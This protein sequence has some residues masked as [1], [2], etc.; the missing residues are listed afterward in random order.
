M[1]ALILFI[2]FIVLLCKGD[3]TVLWIFGISAVL[4]VVITILRKKDI[5][6]EKQQQPKRAAGSGHPRISHPHLLSEDNYECPVCGRRFTKNTMSCPYCHA[7]F[8]GTREDE[9][10]FLDEEE[11]LDM[12]EEDD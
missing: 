8:T 2:L 7:C 10:E 12:M 9:D 5:L 6:P 3:P 11:F 4:A 1:L